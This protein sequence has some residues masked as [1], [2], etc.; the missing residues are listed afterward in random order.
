MAYDIH[1]ERLEPGHCEVHPWVHMEYPCPE[2]HA[3]KEKNTR[4]PRV[5]IATLEAEN[6]RL[7]AEVRQLVSG[8]AY[9]R[10]RG[11]VDRLGGDYTQCAYKFDDCRGALACIYEAATGNAPTPPDG[12]EGDWHTWLIE[13]TREVVAQA[14]A[15]GREAAELECINS[16]CHFCNDGEALSTTQEG[17]SNHWGHRWVTD[18]GVTLISRCDAGPIHSR[19]R[20]RAAAAEGEQGDAEG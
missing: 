16:L 6:E 19:R 2:C 15:D 12:Y 7:K 1:G 20:R 5:R 17:Q 4:N 3:A 10:L 14:H 9:E 11:E 8:E 18:R 13:K